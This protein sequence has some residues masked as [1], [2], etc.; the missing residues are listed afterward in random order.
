MD[1]RFFLHGLEQ[2]GVAFYTGVPD[3]LLKPLNDTLYADHG[4]T[5]AHVVAADEGGAVALAAGHYIATGKPAMVYLQNSGI[6]NAVNPL[7]SLTHGMVYGIPCVL[8]VG[9]RGEPGVHDEP[10][11]AYQGIVT[12]QMLELCGLTVFELDKATS[13]ADFA[14][15]ITAATPLLSR[16]ESVAFLVRKGGLTGGE[17]VVLPQR[18]SMTREAA[19]RCLIR[20]AAETDFFVSTTGKASRELFELREALGQGH[21]RDFLTVGSMGH[22][23]MIALGMAKA[24]PDATFWCV[25]GDGAALM[26]LGGL[27]IEA[28]QCAA[29]LIHV[30]LNNGAH[31]SVG[32]MPVAGGAL[33]FAPFAQ[34]AGYALALTAETEGELAEA[35][36]TLRGA[37]GQLRFLEIIVSCGARDDLGRPTQTPKEN[38]QSLMQALK[39]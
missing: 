29:N 4:L 38:L 19:I 26:H 39:K 5:G 8:V 37:S 6:G 25:D 13:E 35:L 2:L 12:R 31:E 23:N 33:R 7:A 17:P 10:Q 1:T 18:D 14:A 28:Q 16:G 21:G 27:A 9:W 36:Q 22:A 34:A 32:G 11:H 24:R 15:M 30:V 3:S 20:D